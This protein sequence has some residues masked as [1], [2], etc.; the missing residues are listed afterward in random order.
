[1]QNF[2]AFYAIKNLTANNYQKKG[3]F[4]CYKINL[5]YNN[6]STY[7]HNSLYIYIYIYTHIPQRGRNTALMDIINF[8]PPK[9][10]QNHIFH[11]LSFSNIILPIR[12]PLLTNSHGLKTSFYQ[13]Q[14]FQ[15]YNNRSKSSICNLEYNVCT[16]CLTAAAGTELAGAC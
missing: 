7:I 11:L 3:S 13:L 16:L 10:T 15:H 5:K 4:G 14:P 6:N 1:M 2:L 12:S 9:I 8:I